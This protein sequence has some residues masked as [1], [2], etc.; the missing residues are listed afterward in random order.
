MSL[1]PPG[2][3]VVTAAADTTPA[4]VENPCLRGIGI[5]FGR[6]RVLFDFYLYE[7]FIKTSNTRKISL[8]V[9][10]PRVHKK[11]RTIAI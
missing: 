11:Q 2:V 9:S 8:F 4:P 1:R 3:R 5:N 6:F 7:A 10:Y